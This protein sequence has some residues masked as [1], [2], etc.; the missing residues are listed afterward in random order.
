MST[1]RP[2]ICGVRE[3]AKSGVMRSPGAR[4]DREH[5]TARGYV[6]PRPHWSAG[7]NG[8]VQEGDFRTDGNDRRVRSDF[9]EWS[10]RLVPWTG[11]RRN[12]GRDPPPTSCAICGSVCPGQSSRWWRLSCTPSLRSP[13]RW[14]VCYRLTR[15]R[16]LHAAFQNPK[17]CSGTPRR[18][19]LRTW[20]VPT[21]I[22]VNCT[23]AIRWS[24]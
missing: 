11:T 2:R 13:T 24:A 8:V 6:E 7:G 23:Q 5:V 20:L 16:A 19:F 14:P 22:G 3:H 10:A 17:G 1:R 4:E 9:G 21:S 15:L 18:K 12:Q